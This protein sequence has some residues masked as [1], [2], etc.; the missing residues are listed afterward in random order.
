MLSYLI[1]RLHLNNRNDDAIKVLRNIA[2]WNKRTLP[3]DVTLPSNQSN[4]TVH[5][6]NMLHLFKT[7]K[8]CIQTC[9]IMFVWLSTALMSYGL[10]FAA[11]NLGGTVYEN[12]ILLSAT[13]LPAAIAGAALAKFIGR[14]TPTVGVVLLGSITCFAIAGLPDRGAYKIA[15]LALGILG[16]FF[17]V[18]TFACLYIWTPEM[19]ST[20]MRAVAMGVVQLTARVGSG[21]SPVVV[22]VG[23]CVPFVVI[24]I[25]SMLAAGM[26][27]LLPETKGKHLKEG[28]DDD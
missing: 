8:T 28:S 4:V 20:N 9:V 19:Y 13:G 6:P 14:K 24:G 25:V 11:S 22:R 2:K 18:T 27:C 7:R 10:Q 23:G 21:L 15:R 3:D 17:G 1:Y 5:R 16:K 26:G 12:F